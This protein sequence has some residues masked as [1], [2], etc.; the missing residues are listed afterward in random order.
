MSFGKS[1][2]EVR[3]KKGMSQ[4][5]L[6]K[7][8]G[9]KEP[10]SG[11]YERDEMKPSTLCY[12]F[13][14]SLQ[15]SHVRIILLKKTKKP[16]TT[17]FI[18]KAFCMLFVTKIGTIANKLSRRYSKKA[19]INN[20]IYFTGLYRNLKNKKINP[21]SKIAHIINTKAECDIPDFPPIISLIVPPIIPPDK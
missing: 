1:L 3:K 6:A 17:Y 10:V 5:E 2:T 8:L 7:L 4:E 15:Y 20:T 14:Y 19:M 12:Y 21:V 16:I 18:I 9:S 11:R 13:L